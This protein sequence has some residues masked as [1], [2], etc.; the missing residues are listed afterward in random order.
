MTR[1]RWR[2]RAQSPSP[3]TT[4]TVRVFGS[5]E[6]LAAAPVARRGVSARGQADGWC[7][8]AGSDAYRT[9]SAGAA[10]PPGMPA[11]A[12]R[13]NRGDA[14]SSASRARARRLARALPL[15][16][17][18]RAWRRRHESIARDGRRA[19][20][21]LEEGLAVDTRRAATSSNKRAANLLDHGPL[22]R[23][24]QSVI[25]Q[26]H[27]PPIC[28][29]TKMCSRGARASSRTSREP[30]GHATCGSTA[31]CEDASCERAHTSTIV[32]ACGQPSS[33]RSPPSGAS[34][35]SAAAPP[36]PKGRSSRLDGTRRSG[37]RPPTPSPARARIEL[38]THFQKKNGGRDR[39]L[40][41]R[42][43]AGPPVRRR[44]AAE[45][46]SGGARRAH[47]WRVALRAHGRLRRAR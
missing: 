16:P 11:D 3:A 19:P 25:E 29:I 4:V 18:W 28:S 40:H 43:L 46:V 1:R 39:P 17:R 12:A 47:G 23:G 42:R 30:C 20:R 22:A 37:A 31:G 6:P 7:D 10:A 26:I 9:A 14:S 5:S 15:R 38:N 45:H 33:A 34:G 8:G 41:H 13:T 35:A 2:A 44:R 21:A 27:G 36:P 32:V 24:R